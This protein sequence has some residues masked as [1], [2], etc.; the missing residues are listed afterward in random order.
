MTTIKT[1]FPFVAT[2]THRAD[3]PKN[4][5]DQWMVSI[6]GFVTTF[7]KGIGLRDGFKLPLGRVTIE[8]MVD[9][10][11]PTKSKPVSPTCREVLWALANDAQCYLNAR[12]IDDFAKEYGYESS[13]SQAIKAWEG[14]RDAAKFFQARGLDIETYATEDDDNPNEETR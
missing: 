8:D 14:C 2:L 9:F 6:D 12:D 10:N 1:D 3:S 5:T 13:V 4:D 7:S 11:N